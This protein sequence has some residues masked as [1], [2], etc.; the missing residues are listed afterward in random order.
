MEMIQIYRS[1]QH[2][3]S[4]SVIKTVYKL[5]TQYTFYIFMNLHP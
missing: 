3:Y 1:A 2:W 5:D 4:T